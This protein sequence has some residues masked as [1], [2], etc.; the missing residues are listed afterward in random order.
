[1]QNAIEK[2]A[3]IIITLSIIG[4]DVWF[5]QSVLFAGHLAQSA[6]DILILVMMAQ[7]A[8]LASVWEMV[9]KRGSEINQEIRTCSEF[10]WIF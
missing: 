8:L 9:L 4:A 5:A 2:F 3:L 10:T 7:V 1:M 6:K